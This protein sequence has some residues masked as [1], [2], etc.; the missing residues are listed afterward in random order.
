MPPSGW[1]C[2]SSCSHVYQEG[3]TL[4]LL[5]TPNDVDTRFTSWGGDC[6]GELTDQCSVTFNADLTVSASF[7]T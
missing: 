6:A 1:S 7:T 3:T 2:P 5:A 4:T